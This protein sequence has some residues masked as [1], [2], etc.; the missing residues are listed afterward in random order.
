MQPN[1]QQVCVTAITVL[2]GVIVLWLQQRF[3][4]KKTEKWRQESDARTIKTASKI[5]SELS[6]DSG[7]SIKDQM[8][9]LVKGQ[10]EL[11]QL[12][13][14][15]TTMLNA[16]SDVLA[17][18][19]GAQRE[20]KEF[21]VRSAIKDHLPAWTEE[22][23]KTIHDTPAKRCTVLVVDDEPNIIATMK[24]LLRR[25]F[26][27]VGALSAE[28]ALS[29]VDS[30]EVHIV[31]TDQRMPQM[32]GVELLQQLAARHPKPIRILLTGYSD[33]ESVIASINKAHIYRYISKPWMAE[34]MIK[35]L[36]EAVAVY[37]LVNA[38][39]EHKV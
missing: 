1:W 30:R 7:H 22:Q 8:I 11:V 33:V 16:H 37:E 29:I 5:Q 31:I 14:T 25:E 36:R 26:D 27:V 32:S 35:I 9:T 12:T 23:L 4:S 28:E 24:S 10:N 2:G 6:E 13:N 19:V 20:V 15:Q 39:V 18:L 17:A 38:V 21:V 34:D 3:Q